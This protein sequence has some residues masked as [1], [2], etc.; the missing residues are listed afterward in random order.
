MKYNEDVNKMVKVRSEK[1]N[2]VIIRGV[3]QQNVEFSHQCM[4]ENFYKTKIS[5]MRISETEDSIPVII[6]EV[7]IKG[8]MSGKYVQVEGELRSYNLLG[9]DGI[10]HLKLFVF[11]NDIEVL[12]NINEQIN[13]IYMTGYICKP[14]IYRLTPLK[15]R[16]SDLLVAVNR[17]CGKSSY[18]PCIVWG[19]NAKIVSEWNVGDKVMIEGRIQSRKYIKKSSIYSNDMEIREAYELSVSKIERL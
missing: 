8:I 9:E 3:V 18:I 1:C 6:P 17:T 12:D 14:V 15:R 13:V 7:F 19:R 5:I 4:S 2:Q 10:E 11:V 16:I